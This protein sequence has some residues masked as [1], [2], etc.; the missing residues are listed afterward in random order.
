LNGGREVAD[1][2]IRQNEEESHTTLEE[3]R[4]AEEATECERLIGIFVV[5]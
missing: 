4:K 2:A 5:I 3:A 1:E